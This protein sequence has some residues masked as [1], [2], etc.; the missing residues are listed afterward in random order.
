MIPQTPFLFL[1]PRHESFYNTV[2]SK[3][4]GKGPVLLAEV[5]RENLRTRGWEQNLR[6]Q[7]ILNRWEDAVG[8]Q[9]ARRARP[10]HVVNH[11]LTIAV[12]SPAWAQQLS[13]LKKD[14]LTRIHTLL[15]NESIKD[16]YFTSGPG[17]SKPGGSPTPPPDEAPVSPETEKS[18]DEEAS[19]INDPD[20]REAFR[21]VLLAASR[22]RKSPPPSAAPRSEQGR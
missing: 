1:V 9:I 4:R 12:D 13:L 21:S 3:K 15:G 19:R 5:L 20:L 17:D 8:D 14:L 16:L 22:R 18:I 11:R 7:E 6:E 2:M 10:L